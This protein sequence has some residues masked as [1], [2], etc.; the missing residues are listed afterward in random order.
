LKRLFSGLLLFA[1]VLCCGFIS[2]AQSNKGTEFWTAYMDHVNG[3]GGND[4]S[5]MSLYVVSTV[6]TS[7]TV[8]VNDNSFAPITFNLVANQPQEIAIP[9]E[10]FLGESNNDA[11]INK[12]IHIVSAQPIA[13]YAHIY[14][15]SVSG[16][17]LLLP[18]NSLGKEYFSINYTQVS[19]SLVSGNENKNSYS[20]FNIVA[21][22]DNTTIEITP[23]A[24][25]LSGQQAN[26]TF[27]IQLNKGQV[28]Q[29]LSNTD[30]TGTL[31]RSIASG[32]E[33]CKKIAVFSGSSKIGIG[34]NGNAS[35]GIINATS[36]NLFQQVYPTV[37]WG[38]NYYAV[39]L[40]GRDYDIF[41]VVY[42]DF[43]AQVKVNGSTVSPSNGYYEFSSQ[44]PVV[45][46]SD[47][48]VQ[49]V[50]YTVSQG[51]GLGCPTRPVANDVGDPEM[52][53]LPPIEQGLKQVTLF[54][55]S[56]S[57]INS[58][59]Q[60]INVILP[61]SAVSSFKID[62]SSYPGF[63]AMPQDL[64]YVYAQINVSPGSHNISAAKPFTAIAYG[65]GSRES[66]GYAA[67]T[68][69]QNLNEYIDL[70]ENFSSSAPLSNGCANTNYLVQLV[71]PNSS[72]PFIQWKSSD[73]TV[74]PTD[75]NPQV[76]GTRLSDNGITTLY[77]YQL[78]GQI[79][80]PAGY[81]NITAS[82]P[83]QG[84]NN[85][86]GPLHDIAFDF[87]I[88][89]FPEANF[90]TQ[91]GTC[92]NVPVTFTDAS[93]A[94]G[95]T[96]VSWAW[97][98]GDAYSTA[99]NPNSSTEQ[100]PVHTFTRRGIYEVTLSV[101]NQNGCPSQVVKT[102]KVYINS[103]PEVHILP[104]TPDCATQSITFL[105]KS[106]TLDGTI[107]KWLW[108][109]EDSNASAANKTS[110]LKNP[111]HTYTQPGTYKVKLQ[112]TTDSSCVSALD[113]I[114]VTVYP[115]PK[116]DFKLPDVCLDNATATFINKSSIA[117][118]TTL[119]YKWYFDDPLSTAA[120]N[121]STQVNGTHTYHEVR[122]ASNP[123]HVKLTVTSANGCIK[124]TTLNLI[125][126]GS[127]PTP[128]FSLDAANTYC[129]KDSVV[130]NDES[131]PDF[132]V[133]T[134]LRW[135]YDV[136]NKPNE[137]EEFLYRD[138]TIHSSKKYK[139]FYGISHALASRTFKVRLEVSSGEGCEYSTGIVPVTVFPN[140]VVTLGNVPAEICQEKEAIQITENTNGFTGAPGVFTGDGITAGGLFNPKNAGPG[141]H[142]IKYVFKADVT[143]CPDEQTF[144]IFVNPTPIISGKRNLTIAAGERV[145][146][147]PLGIS[148]NGANLTYKWTPALGLDRTNVA[149]PVA[150]P[151]KDTQYMLTITSAN[152]CETVALFNI[153]VL[154]QPVTYNTFTPNGDGR[155]DTWEIPNMED[156]PKAVVEVF[157]RNGQ[158]VFYSLGYPVPWDGRYN[159]TD[160]PAATYYYVID[161]KDGKKPLSG[162]LTIIR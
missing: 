52:I 7:G 155:N 81:Y 95:S 13:A 26:S 142:I 56:K 154:Q 68:N 37:T 98:F 128:K 25:L 64:N 96:L 55:T 153:T 114:M 34:C 24:A 38:K 123:Y 28:Y 33:L 30:L 112:V 152:Q 115:Q 32:T 80:K 49:L 162:P 29:G 140:P 158:R 51:E 59:K 127:N 93:D 58:D 125:V 1:A 107:N 92:V 47:K 17:T 15:S 71:V 66:Y 62:G 160:L 97:N 103:I 40:K 126:N 129:S 156:H 75:N 105:D 60:F 23:K 3:A 116:A 61:A 78:Q 94:K 121:T 109:F 45:V 84:V 150:S 139:H 122:D 131:V 57:G 42:S 106:T 53:F 79:N 143:Q 111:T 12:G 157:N 72:L 70:K 16:A 50:Q 10:A 76:V 135:Y 110:I 138:G 108:T 48:P 18:V 117:D 148:L 145:T 73:G 99:I 35:T 19:N 119:T 89:D 159:G 43:S 22:E 67:G 86:C 5:Q 133:I 118:H 14:R 124:D 161:L 44:E 134:R 141:L 82:I 85:D 4:G 69:L 91:T 77:V 149:N 31:I 113:S 27:T 144:N 88:S 8:S 20:L 101:I 6:N 137:Y 102:K 2:Y 63:I 87:N 39:P 132:G 41:R 120:N 54:S 83:N 100:N 147:E 151:A 36:D 74:I 65:F 130:F 104:S 146:L 46:T 136:E 11:P 21:T 90:A 9:K